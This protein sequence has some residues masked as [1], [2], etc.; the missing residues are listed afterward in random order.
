MDAAS[1]SQ[2]RPGQQGPYAP[3]SHFPV[4]LSSALREQKHEY[5]GDARRPLGGYVVINGVY[6]ALAGALV[7]AARARDASVPSSFSA[8]DLVVMTV[9]T[10]KLS[11]LIAKDPITSPLRAPFTRFKGQSG[12][13]ELAEEVRGEGLQ[14]AV[15]E[16][17]TCPFCIGQ[18]TATAFAGGSILAPRFTRMAALVGT[19]VAG[20]DVLQY[21]FAALQLGWKRASSS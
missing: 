10:A 16:L 17:L 15:G 18:W 11:R 12:E 21:G 8:G 13:A 14:H 19:L 3:H 4:T 2:D 9:A 1:S 7:A 6:L 20:A 5:A